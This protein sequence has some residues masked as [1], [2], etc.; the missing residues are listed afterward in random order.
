MYVNIK[1]GHK[2]SYETRCSWDGKSAK[3]F[4]NMSVKIED[5]RYNWCHH[6]KNMM[7]VCVYRDTP[8]VRV[9]AMLNHEFF[10]E[11][12]MVKLKDFSKEC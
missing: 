7:C 4:E 6:T 9:Q 1:F 10:L 8:L 5:R 12:K 11:N 3:K 2:S